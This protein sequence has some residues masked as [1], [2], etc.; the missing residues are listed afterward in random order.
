MW[1]TQFSPEDLHKNKPPTPNPQ[2]PN[3]AILW[4]LRNEIL[5]G[6]CSFSYN[7]NL[8]IFPF[9]VSNARK[10]LYKMS[11]PGL[12]AFCLSCKDS[13]GAEH[14]RARMPREMIRL[15]HTSAPVAAA[16]REWTNIGTRDE[17]RR[18]A[19]SSTVHPSSLCSYS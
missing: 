2:Q 3:R 7:T 10:L 6:S 13:R 11:S 8:S 12:L 18:V 15:I 5:R 19:M 1:K 9:D 16:H 4:T 17:G 14:S